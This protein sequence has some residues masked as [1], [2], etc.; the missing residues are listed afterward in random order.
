MSLLT[1]S[2][3]SEAPET[4]SPAGALARL[5][6]RL[7]ALCGAEL[8]WVP[9]PLP[10]PRGRRGAEVSAEGRSAGHLLAPAG[11]V[12]A[13]V[14]ESAAALAAEQIEREGGIAALADELLRS[15]EQ[16]AFAQR[17]VDSLTPLTDTQRLCET[18][19]DETVR[20]LGARS[21]SLR[22]RDEKGTESLCLATRSARGADARPAEEGLEVPIRRPRPSGELQ[23]MGTLRVAGLPGGEAPGAGDPLLARALAEQAALLIHQCRIAE[24]ARRTE[25]ARREAE[26]AREVQS[27]LLPHEDPRPS[28]LEVAG[29]CVP[30]PEVGGDHYGYL[31][32][33]PGL[34]GLMMIDVSGDGVAAAVAMVG[35]RSLLRAEAARAD[36]P[37][38]ALAAA[39]HLL[40]RD[41]HPSGLYATAFLARYEESRRRLRYASAGHP[42]ALLWRSGE[43]RFER[44][45]VGGLALGIFDTAAYEQG[46]V[47]LEPGDL[48]ILFSDGLTETR[49]PAG[50]AFT[51]ERVCQTVMRHRRERPRTILYR[52]LE[53]AEAFRDGQPQGDDLTVMV[54][55]AGRGTP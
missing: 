25:R 5:L 21:V 41:L 45:E 9:A 23:E 8:E 15:W 49:D 10:P 35:V 14:L 40:A 32:D 24:E 4:A 38:A 34:P 30:G 13:G 47:D 27:G 28:G 16:Q 39:N 29:A 53:A 36:A 42:P 55:R 17:L 26:I 12:H 7:R 22:L 46:E 6:E 54:L 33:R 44:L 31:A 48:V 1:R 52:L 20:A 51:L 18:I 11:G 19:L 50:E 43:G 3:A 37:A 2:P